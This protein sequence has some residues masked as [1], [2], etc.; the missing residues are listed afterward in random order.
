M[1]R[2]FLKIGQAVWLLQSN[3]CGGYHEKGE[4]GIIVSIESPH[5]FYVKSIT[6]GRGF[7]HELKCVSEHEGY[8][9]PELF[10]I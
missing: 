9:E 6:T 3:C 4:K 7:W 2:E 1:K 5:S 10:E 8:F